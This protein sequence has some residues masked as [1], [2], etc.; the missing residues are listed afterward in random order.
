MHSSSDLVDRNFYA[1]EANQFWVADST[2]VPTWAGFHYVAVV[3]D[4]FSRRVVGWPMGTQPKAQLAPDAMTMAVGWRNPRDV[5]H[6]SDQGTQYTSVAFGLRCNEAGVRHSMGFVGNAYANAP[7]ERFFATMECEFLDQHKF[8]TKA[9]AR[10]AVH[11]FI[12]GWYNPGCRPSVLG[13]LSPIDHEKR[14]LDPL[15]ISSL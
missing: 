8:Q 6:H 4:A 9:E 15:E 12:P 2:Y 14:A 13:Y 7:R 1:E 3:L 10:M 11:Q 5:I